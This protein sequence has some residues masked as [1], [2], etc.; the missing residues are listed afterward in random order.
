MTI[1]QKEKQ[2]TS[3]D[4]GPPGLIVDDSSSEVSSEVSS[5]DGWL[6]E[7]EFVGPD[8]PDWDKATPLKLIN[9]T[10]SGWQVEVKF[11]D[12][13]KVRAALKII[14]D[15]GPSAERSGCSC[16]SD[17]DGN[18]EPPHGIVDSD[19]EQDVPDTHAH[20]LSG[21]QAKRHKERQERERAE[22][23]RRPFLEAMAARRAERDRQIEESMPPKTKNTRSG[24]KAPPL[25]SQPKTKLPVE[26]H[27][28]GRSRAW[29]AST[30]AMKDQ[31]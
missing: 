23:Q 13:A 17:S 9:P 22:Q 3:D 29:D 14:E 30:I 18:E 19:D 4:D 7:D 24:R 20:L 28:V 21:L 26:V 27:V 1:A 16:P 12:L 8:H 11:E 15:N 6:P 25:M 31:W 10:M 2:Q 5:C